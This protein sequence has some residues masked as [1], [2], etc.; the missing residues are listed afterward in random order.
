MYPG[1]LFSFRPHLF[2][3]QDIEIIG[4]YAIPICPTPFFIGLYLDFIWQNWAISH[5]QWAI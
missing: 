1:Q 3:I 2:L 4:N 5:L